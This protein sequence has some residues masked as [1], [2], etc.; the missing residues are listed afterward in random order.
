M[1]RLSCAEGWYA[2]S[3]NPAEFVFINTL[4]GRLPV[5]AALKG[6]FD[7][8]LRLGGKFDV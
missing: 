2:F 8:L 3:R 7:S 1:N 4:T 5:L 6:V